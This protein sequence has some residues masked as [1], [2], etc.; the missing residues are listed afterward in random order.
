MWI[1]F[2]QI[3]I[4]YGERQK[5]KLRGIPVKRKIRYSSYFPKLSLTEITSLNLNIPRLS[6]N[7]KICSTQG[8]TQ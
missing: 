8:E 6:P 4:K 5:M 7:S 3:K 1:C 2:L